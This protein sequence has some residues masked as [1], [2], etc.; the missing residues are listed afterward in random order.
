MALGM[1]LGM[2]SMAQ[3]Q[4]TTGATPTYNPGPTLPQIDGTFQY[5]LFAS[6]VAETGFT[7]NVNAS[8]NLGGTAEIMS[9]STVAPFSLLYTGGY[10]MT[11][12]PS[13]SNSTF[14]ALTASQGFIGGGWVFG[15]SDTVSFL[16]S[17]PTGSLSGVAG[18]GDIGLQPISGG[19]IPA[20]TV[21]TDYSRRISNSVNGNVER[22]LNPR[23][24]I[25]GNG[26]YGI[27]RFL[28]GDGEN[29]TQITGALSLNRRLN[30]RNTLSG[31][32]SYST[33][34]FS[35]VGAQPTVVSRGL[36]IVYERL[37]TRA[38]TTTISAGPQWI[39]GYTLTPLQLQNYPTGT[40][41][42]IPGRV[43][44][45]VNASASYTRGYTVGTLSYSRGINAG[46][47]VYQGATGDTLTGQVSRSFGPNWQGSATGAL[48]RTLGLTGG[49]ATKTFSFG[50]QVTRRITRHLSGYISDVIQT[51]S[52][53]TLAG[54]NAFNGTSNSVAIGISYSPRS[55]RLGQF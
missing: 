1:I 27:L 52:V 20:Q 30:A 54:T 18:S 43:T 2:G 17:A 31:N 47:G 45:A 34:S 26:S 29:N 53:G 25:S 7:N 44:A 4:A 51:Q 38:L 19:S 42:V 11:T 50:G 46:S 15:I 39:S 8:T 16:P 22:S 36:N 24:S 35:G 28:D 6:E 14:Q 9:K 55:T 49:S 10:I 41:P 37:W 33:Y 13:F 3:G 48:A 32:V 21:L 12:E 5:S 40:N 23:T